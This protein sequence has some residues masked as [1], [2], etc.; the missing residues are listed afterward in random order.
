M[1]SGIGSWR[2]H[3]NSGRFVGS[4]PRKKAADWTIVGLWR[5]LVNTTPLARTNRLKREPEPPRAER[6]ISGFASY[7]DVIRELRY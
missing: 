4:R 2:R 5:T 7:S 6:P 1:L 3:E